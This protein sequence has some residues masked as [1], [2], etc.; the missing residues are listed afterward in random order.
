LYIYDILGREVANLVG[1]VMPPGYQ[2]VVWNTN[3]NLGIS[4][5]AGIYFYQIQTKEFI[6]TKK[7]VI[8]K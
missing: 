5:S 1:Q 7:M 8:L 3:N 2:S 6:K 4:V